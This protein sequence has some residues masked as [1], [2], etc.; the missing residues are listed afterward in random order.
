MQALLA[1]GLKHFVVLSA[2]LFGLGLF[3]VG[4][5]RNAV[6]I[7]MGVA[8]FSFARLSMLP[9][10]ERFLLDSVFPMIHIGRLHVDMAFAMDPLSAMMA[11]IITLIG[12]GIHIYS[13]GYMAEEP[14]YWRFFCYL[15]LFIF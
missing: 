8:L 1:V 2:I 13:T 10:S 15:N 5:R 7:L 3:T 14:S 12:T 6:A 11:L 9:A 4:T